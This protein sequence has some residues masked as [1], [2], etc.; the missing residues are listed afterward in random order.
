MAVSKFQLLRQPLFFMIK[1]KQEII[2][3]GRNEM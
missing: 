3:W 1:M 2:E